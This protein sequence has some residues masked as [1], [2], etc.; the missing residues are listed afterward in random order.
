[1][2]GAGPP[3]CVGVG[4]GRCQRSGLYLET[5]DEV[6]PRGKRKNNYL[7]IDGI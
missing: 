2:V 5:R 7:I 6:T 3:G 1:M 4:T